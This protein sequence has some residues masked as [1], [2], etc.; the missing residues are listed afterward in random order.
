VSIAYQVVGEGPV[1]L[2]WVPAFA[3][4]V[5]LAW[6]E[7]FRAAWLEGLAA[8]FRLI[9]FDKRGTGL[10]DRVAGPQTLETRM[11]DIRAV[12]DAAGSA[13]ALVA[14]AGDAGTLALLFAASHP[15]RTRGLAL[16]AAAASQ[17]WKPDM[18]WLPP[19]EAVERAIEDWERHWARPEW[20]DEGAML[21]RAAGSLTPAQRREF[22][23]VLRLSVSPGNFASYMRLNL[24]VDVRGLL[25][26]VRVPTLVL[27]R[28]GVPDELDARYL[29]D[30]IPYARL[31]EVPGD[32]SIRSWVTR[33]RSWLRS[34]SSAWRR[35]RGS[36][37]TGPSACWRRSSSPTSSAPPHG[38]LRSATPRGAS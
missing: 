26:S 20:W 35:R 3:Q 23:R 5:E 11:D 28:T 21:V 16:F 25:A 34:G 1:D 30:R 4:H 10:S 29:V 8:S 19:R 14:A 31:V 37:Q 22:G 17:T 2:V 13:R 36:R 7:P 6:E 38:R 15:E 24:D 12:M 33:R 18:P 27:R 32:D 9:V